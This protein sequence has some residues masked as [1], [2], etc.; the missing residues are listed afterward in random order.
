MP[1]SIVNV[2]PKLALPQGELVIDLSGTPEAD[3]HLSSITANG[4][5][6]F[7][8]SISARRAVVEL[9]AGEQFETASF[10]SH[11][12]KL[13]LQGASE[14]ADDFDIWCGRRRVGGMHIVANPAIDPSDG[15]MI[16]TRS[17][18]RGEQLDTTLFRVG[19]NGEVEALPENI[20]NPTAVAFSPAGELYVTN[21]ASGEVLVVGR[22]G[23]S[24]VFSA[25]L[26]IATGLAF[27]KRG[28]LYVGDRSGRIY[29][30][31]EY[32]DNEVFAEIEPSVAAFHMAFGP[33]DALYVTAPGLSSFDPVY[34]VDPDGEVS[35]YFT[36][37]GRPQGLAFDVSGNLYVAACRKGRRGIFRIDANSLDAELFVSGQDIVGSCFD[38]DGNLLVATSD[39]VYSF[40]VGIKGTLLK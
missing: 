3:L 34:R 36:G 28:T 8:R 29:R 32:G 16:V 13:R 20:M 14:P 19:A 24:T 40:E 37:F 23:L 21:R 39:S 10:Q 22:E 12:C 35:K 25:N 17:G 26:G 31:W 5:E 4:C 6:C 33:D 11:S 1:I 15:S 27:D 38:R 7:V 9:P 30:V 2:S 18:R